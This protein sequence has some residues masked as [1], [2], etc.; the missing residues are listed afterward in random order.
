V[1]LKVYS[2]KPVKVLTS[3]RTLAATEYRDMVMSILEDFDT[4]LGHV[5][6]A[7]WEG[8]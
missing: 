8:G 3:Y 1:C 4:Y 6:V 5:V 7:R 2:V